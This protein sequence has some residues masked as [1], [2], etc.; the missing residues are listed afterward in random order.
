MYKLEYL[1]VARQDMLDIVT[2]ITDELKNPAAA[3]KLAIAFIDAI[4]MLPAFPYAHAVYLPLKPLKK[5]YRRI[6]VKKYNVFYWVEEAKKKVVIARIIYG[7]R[8]CK[9]IL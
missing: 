6:V 3:L 8:E 4:E 2:Y 5:E 7:K 9:K 1:P